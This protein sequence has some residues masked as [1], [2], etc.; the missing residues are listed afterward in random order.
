MQKR[1]KSQI[2][3]DDGFQVEGYLAADDMCLGMFGNKKQYENP[4]TTVCMANQIF[5]LAE[6][7][8]DWNWGARATDGKHIDAV[9]G[10]GKE[11]SSMN[12]Q[13]WLARAAHSDKIKHVAYSITLVPQKLALPIAMDPTIPSDRTEEELMQT[14]FLTLGGYDE[15]DLAGPV[16]WF[17]AKH[18]WNQTLTEFSFDGR[19]IIESYEQAQVMIETG[20]PYIGMTEQYFDKIADYLKQSVSR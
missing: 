17:D 16:T 20:Y 5:L 10:L 15:K 4:E 3:Q 2:V 1:T 9:C 18:T 13:G 8:S 14:S 6:G 7:Q 19:P 12:A 11:K